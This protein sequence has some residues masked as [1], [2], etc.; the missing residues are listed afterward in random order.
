MLIDFNKKIIHLI[1]KHL[2][3]NLF[4]KRCKI[5]FKTDKDKT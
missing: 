4:L 1:N 5:F 3:E 2:A